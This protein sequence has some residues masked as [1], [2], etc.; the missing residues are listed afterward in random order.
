MNDEITT[1]PYNGMAPIQRRDS[2][3]GSREGALLVDSKLVS[4]RQR[5]YDFLKKNG[6]S[7][8]EQ[9]RNGIGMK[10]KTTT[11]RRRE[12]ELNGAVT[13]L[14]FQRKNSKGKLVNVYAVVAKRN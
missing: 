12:L 13:R 14:G 10:P 2:T 8:D 9:V 5:V 3:G 4:Y 6:P 1:N 11:A 7:T